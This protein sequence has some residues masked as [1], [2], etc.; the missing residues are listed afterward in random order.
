M[1]AKKESSD[2]VTNRKARHEYTIEETYEA[3]IELKGTEVKSIRK[4]S[5][6]LQDAYVSIRHGEA[7]IESMHI[8]PYEEGNRFNVDPLRSRRLLLHKKEIRKIDEEIKKQGLTVIP[9]KLYLNR[10]MVKVQIAL[11]RGKKLHDKRDA[12]RER[13]TKRKIDKAMKNYY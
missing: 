7:F 12:I 11:A 6:N 4:G 5:A 2:L 8:S 3:G 1:A 9:L 10:G 13:E